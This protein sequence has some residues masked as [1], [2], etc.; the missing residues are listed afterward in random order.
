M[1]TP[2]TE[3]QPMRALKDKGVEDVRAIIRRA[4]EMHSKER[5]GEDDMRR[6]VDSA[7]EL[8][9]NIVNATEYDAYGNEIGGD[10]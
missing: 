9:A 3:R 4:R 2:T 7:Y 10:A 5:L 1:S 6:I 8:E